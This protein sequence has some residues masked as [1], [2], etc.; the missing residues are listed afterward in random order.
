MSPTPGLK[1]SI[2]TDRSG[3]GVQ[4]HLGRFHLS[5]ADKTHNLPDPQL[6]I[7]RMFRHQVA[8]GCNRFGYLSACEHR[9]GQ[10]APDMYPLRLELQDVPKLPFCF[11]EPADLDQDETDP[12]LK[13]TAGWPNLCGPLGIIKCSSCSETERHQMHL[14]TVKGP[15]AAT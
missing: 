5:C 3:R 12:F 7:G 11:T 14:A 6:H 13:S 15:E 1:R 2:V 10:R 4:G 8:L 9:V